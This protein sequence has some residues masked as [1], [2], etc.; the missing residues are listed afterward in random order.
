M[1]GIFIAASQ[2]LIMI[3]S[4]RRLHVRLLALFMLVVWLAVPRLA[5]AQTTAL[6]IDSRGHD[7]IGGTIKQTYTPFDGSFRIERN[8]V[9]G[10]SVRFT[11]SAT[12]LPRWTLDFS[13]NNADLTPGVYE[14]A[15]RY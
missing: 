5:A 6:F 8:F 14:F 10:V 13:A 12:Q 11:P 9:K 3:T 15:R 4:G 2:E 1:S 7:P